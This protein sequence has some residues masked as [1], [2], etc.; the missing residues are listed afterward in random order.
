MRF[1]RLFGSALVSIGLAACTTAQ[2]AVP[3]PEPFTKLYLVTNGPHPLYATY[4]DWLSSRPPGTATI[5]A[6]HR[7]I[8][9]GRVARAERRFDPHDTA[10]L[11]T[12]CI[13]DVQSTSPDEQDTAYMWAYG[14]VVRCD[15][16]VV[17][18]VLEPQMGVRP[19][20][21]WVYDGQMGYFPMSL[22]DQ[23]VGSAPAPRH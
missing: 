15:E 11:L 13:F 7:T 9:A 21:L 3:T 10:W 8:E 17:D 16:P 14:R 5:Q 23:Y 1:A 4:G 20:K 18:G 6:E 19:N 12:G 22:L 2:P